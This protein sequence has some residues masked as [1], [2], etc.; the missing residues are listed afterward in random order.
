MDTQPYNVVKYRFT[1]KLITRKA[2]LSVTIRDIARRLRVST[3]AVS[4][5]LNQRPSNTRLS[6]ELRER[7]RSTAEEMGYRPHV[8][9]KA[10]NKKR[11]NLIT[12]ACS[13]LRSQLYAE[14]II[15]AEDEMRVAGFQVCVVHPSPKHLKTDISIYQLSDGVIHISSAQDAILPDST[16]ETPYILIKS[17]PPPGPVTSHFTW[18]DAQGSSLIAMHLG[19]LGHR[20]VAVLA[21]SRRDPIGPPP[22]RVAN[23]LHY[24]AEEGIEGLSVWTDDLDDPIVIGSRLMHRALT[25]YPGIT[26]VVGRNHLLTLGAYMWCLQAGVPIPEQISLISHVDLDILA[27]V[28]PGITAVRVPLRD[29]VVQAV[30]DLIAHLNDGTPLEPCRNWLCTL[31]VRGS[32]RPVA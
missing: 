32:T 8:A 3:Q 23:V 28:Q 9:A 18:D 27:H 5:A 16:I 29:A 19:E 1:N 21:G 13:D 6:P 2:T 22:G 14:A 12:I 25:L 31:E 11:T 17:G 30:H 10:L 15:A 4:V 20:R 26:A 24:L 7:I